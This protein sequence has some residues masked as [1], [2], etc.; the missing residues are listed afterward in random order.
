MEPNSHHSRHTSGAGSTPQGLQV[1][2]AGYSLTAINAPGTA[3]EPGELSFRVVDAEGGPVT[4][5]NELHTK[6]LHLIVVRQDTRHFRHVH[7]VMDSDGTWRIDWSWPTGGTY[8]VFADFQ[9]ANTGQSLTL[10][11]TFDV[12]GMYQPEELPA[13]TTMDQ[14]GDYAVH[15]S[16]TLRAGMGSELAFHISKDGTPVTALEPYLGAYGHLVALRVGDLAYLHVHPSGE[17]GDGITASGPD[18]VF[19]AAAPSAGTYRLFFDFQ[20]EGEVHTASF[21]MDAESQVHHGMGAPDRG[22]AHHH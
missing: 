2:E 11:R 15:L 20:V 3:G 14:A 4:A 16:G 7:P 19:H 9:P 1:S 21:T 18:V 17:P 12:A 8:K 13:V 22:S 6:D 5:Y 10:A